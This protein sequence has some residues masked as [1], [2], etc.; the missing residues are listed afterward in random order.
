MLTRRQK[1]LKCASASENVLSA[2]KDT[3]SLYCPNA[4]DDSQ[5]TEFCRGAATAL[6]DPSCDNEPT[7]KN[8]DVIIMR[9]WYETT[10]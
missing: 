3:L 6:A 7:V 10:V 8:E 4:N 9:Q 5:P 1:I 2:N